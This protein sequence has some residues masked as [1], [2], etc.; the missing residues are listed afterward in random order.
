[1]DD[2]LILQE[3]IE[4]A[5]KQAQ[6]GDVESQALLGKYYSTEPNRDDE[7]AFKWLLMAAKQGH[8]ESMMYVGYSYEV[9]EGAE[10]NI[11]K[12]VFYYSQAYFK[13]YEVCKGA[14]LKYLD[15][16]VLYDKSLLD[17][18]K[19]WTKF[20]LPCYDIK[21]KE[22]WHEGENIMKEDI[23]YICS[24][25]SI[26]ESLINN[27]K[28]YIHNGKDNLDIKQINA[29][30]KT[31]RNT[32][33]PILKKWGIYD[34]VL[35]GNNPFKGAVA[36]LDNTLELYCKTNDLLHIIKERRNDK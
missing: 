26:L 10:R 2:D 23:D 32:I 13:G 3:L 15:D 14:A 12:A 6:E 20:I 36:K 9:G 29:D 21:T 22:E 30:I 24:V 16:S 28:Y 17:K 34:D 4:K 33:K 8:G 25:L 1:M 11:Y 5:K 35:A 27:L 19:D 7:E 31:V 18:N